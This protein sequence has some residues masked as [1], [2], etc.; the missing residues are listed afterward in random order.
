MTP[1]D[2]IVFNKMY[3]TIKAMGSVLNQV[4]NYNCPGR[5]EMNKKWTELGVMM[6]ELNTPPVEIT[7][8]MVKRLREQSGEGMMSCKR[9]LAVS[10][11]DYDAAVEF[12]HRMGCN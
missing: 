1:A 4:S 2:I 12:L 6:K 8:E 5:G 10:N 3:E 11:G 9:A 7:S